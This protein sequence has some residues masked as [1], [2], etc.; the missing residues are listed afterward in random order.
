MDVQEMQEMQKSPSPEHETPLAKQSI[1]GLQKMQEM[2][3]YQ[4]LPISAIPAIPASQ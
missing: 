1:I 2:Q 3:K 4:R